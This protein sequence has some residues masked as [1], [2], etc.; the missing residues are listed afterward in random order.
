MNASSTGPRI[1]RIVAA[2]ALAAACAGCS[3]LDP[4][5]IIGREG[6]EAA[7]IPDAYVP[8]RI[9]A[10][11]G[12]ETRLRAFDFVWDTIDRRYHDP[13]FNG[14][15]WKAVGER[16]RP[17]ALA[18]PS[19]PAFWDVLDRM[20]GELRDSHTRVES[21]RDV[22]LRTRHEAITLGFTMLPVEGKLA[23]AT[24][25]PNGDAWWA[26][27]RPGMRVTAIDGKPAAQ[28]YAALLAQSRQA[29]TDRARFFAAMRR[30]VMGAE[31]SKVS[32]T[33]DRSDGERFDATLPRERIQRPLRE[34]HRVLPSGF[35]YLR[36]SEWSVGLTFR[37]LAA[38]DKLHD[39]PGI[40]IDLRGNPG[41]SVHMVNAMLERFF[42]RRTAIGTAT[43]RNGKS[44]SLLFG[45]VEIIRL[46]REIEGNPNAYRGPV[47]ILVDGGSAS[48]SELFAGTMQAVGR[49]K[50]VGQPSCGCLLGF[51]GYAKVPGGAELA[52][53][54][55][56]FVL[57]NGRHVEGEGVIPDVTVPITL[58]DLSLYRDRTLEAAEALLARESTR[59]PR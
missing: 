55:V 11:L 18:A 24:V 30:L 10:P 28:A 8:G 6:E 42:T 50:V 3:L 43:T 36:F 31:G 26:G 4:Y 29:S 23:V 41:G 2:L 35:G 13:S 46:K 21:P 57:A 49:A 53:S 15:D 39:T 58:S 56:G 33:F 7:S 16:Y 14:V 34:T 25:N 19:D 48:G 17:L 51:L 52:Y 12:R 59:P 22:Q 20:T 38:L 47:A 9:D 40:I 1:A 32:F 5:N 27:V 44:V 54:E 45:T 37:A